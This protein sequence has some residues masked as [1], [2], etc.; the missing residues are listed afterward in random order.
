MVNALFYHEGDLLVGHCLELDIV[1]TGKD[2]EE[3]KNKMRDL[4]IAQVR[5]ALENDNMEYLYKPAPPEIWK[6]FWECKESELTRTS[7][8]PALK[9]GIVPPTMFLQS[10]YAL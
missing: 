1:A 7:R 8:I 10:C 5:Y 9:K 4:I 2:I 6:M 3:A